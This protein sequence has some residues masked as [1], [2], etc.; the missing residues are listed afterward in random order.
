[1]YT[2]TKTF[3][4][5]I[6]VFF[7]VIISVLFLELYV[8]L[9]VDNGFN[10]E[11]EMMKYANKLKKTEIIDDQVVFLHK[12][13]FEGSIMKAKIKTDQNG[14]RF[15]LNNNSD[16]VIM[17]LGDSMTFGFGSNFTFADYLQENFDNNY[18]I[19]NTGV[20]NTNTFMQE[21]SF[22]K[23]HKI[24]KPKILILNFLLTTWRLLSFKKKIL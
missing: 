1:M 3:Y 23:Y 20:G 22:F 7:S 8:R 10:Y 19:M 18:K 13:N 2:A 14:F 11:L 16:E 4:Y 12:P 21:K 15:K 5:I 24:H 9:I 17:L 6:S